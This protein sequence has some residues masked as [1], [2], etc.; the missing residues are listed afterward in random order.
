MTVW[1]ETERGAT[2]P[3]GCG[4]IPKPQSE[5]ATL[6][7]VISCGEGNRMATFEGFTE[8]DLS[9]YLQCLT[10][11]GFSMIS[12]TE[13]N[14]NRFSIY[15]KNTCQ[16]VLYWYPGKA[17]FK[18]ICG[19]AGYLP[20]F[21]RPAVDP[22]CTPE[23][24]QLGRIAAGESYPNGAP[25]MSYVIRLSD[26]RFIVIDGGPRDR[27]GK[28]E[29]ALMDFLNREK[30]PAQER[31][32]IALWII[33][34]AHSDHTRLAAG[35]LKDHHAEV[36]VQTL[37][38]QFP[39][40]EAVTMKEDAAAL[41]TIAM[42]FKAAAEAYL[43]GANRLILHTGMVFW[44]G[45]AKIE[46]LFTPENH[47]PAV[48]PTGNHTSI[49]FCMQLGGKRMVFLGDSERSNCRFMAEAYGTYLKS[50]ILQVTHHGV[51]G[52]SLDLYQAI[53]PEICFWAI[54]ERRFLTHPQIRGERA[55]DYNKWIL[56]DTVRARTHYH[57]SK[58]AT[59]L[60][61]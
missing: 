1:K 51:N 9:D 43:P 47:A 12:E 13:M 52:G 60:L 30:P 56:D 37:A 34:H 58:T 46:V 61:K 21:A 57:T 33:T 7:Q 11:S 31:P 49:A 22:V 20:E 42:Q 40:F 28:D 5:S 19:P 39:D 55:W 2:F 36:T 54:D 41:Q 26:G 59:I 48:F 45:D 23:V 16:V 17:L 29:E 50:D 24:T 25:G 10:A 53:D 15:R 4:E 3:A 32:V 38:F 27:E 44:V 35:F 14:G 6:S 8:K 18:V